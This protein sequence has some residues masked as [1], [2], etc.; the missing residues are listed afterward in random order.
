MREQTIITFCQVAGIRRSL[1]KAEMMKHSHQ[2]TESGF[3]KES[4]TAASQSWIRNKVVA[5]YFDD[6]KAGIDELWEGLA[7]TKER[8]STNMVSSKTNALARTT[9]ASI[10]AS[11]SNLSTEPA[12]F[13]LKI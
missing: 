5:H 6:D 9:A 2:T 1:T 3:S 7:L 8:L 13:H 10:F 12:E 11:K 4:I